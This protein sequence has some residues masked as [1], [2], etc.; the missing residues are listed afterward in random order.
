MT[1]YTDNLC[2]N[3]SVE[4]DLAG[5]VALAGTT[6][7][8]DTTQGKYGRNSMK[9]VTS[10]SAVGQGFTTPQATVPSTGTGSMSFHI[11]GGTGTLTISAI[12]GATPT[13]IASTNITMSGGDYQRVTLAGLPLTSGQA[14]YLLVQ[15]NS[16]EAL[17]FWVDAFQYEMNATPHPYIDGSF[18]NCT[19][20]GTP[21]SSSSFQAFQFP[22][23]SIGGLLLSGQATPVQ[24]GEIFQTSAL[25]QLRLSG[26]E[27]GTLTVNPAG[28]LSAFG[29]WTTADFDPAVSMAIYSNAQSSSGSGAWNRIYGT[30]Y[31]PQQALGSNGKAIWNRAAFA[32]PGFT[33]KSMLNNGQQITSD[34]QWERAPVVPGASPAPTTWQPPRQISATIKPSRLNFCPNP[35]MEVSAAGWT[36]IGSA[37]LSQDSSITMVQGTH[38][39][40]VAIHASTD[41]AYIMIPDLIVGD[42]Y[43]VS[44]YVQGGAGLE[45]VT[46]ACSGSSVSSANLGIPYGGDLTHGY[47]QGPYG[48]VE[49]TGADM[50]TGQWFRPFT[51]FVARASTVCLSFQIIAG[52]DISYPTAFWVDA[53][54]VETGDLLKDY[55][56]GGFG[57]DYSWEGGGTAGLTR[58]YYYQRQNVSAGAVSTALATHTPLGI[59][60]ASPVYSQPYTQ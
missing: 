7:S 16:A 14:M 4:N 36:A 8:L 38:G 26:T 47:G 53:V 57:T 45:D 48:G 32:A 50:P 28:A 23:G 15:T 17:T 44:A 13:V 2:V 34:V 21:G 43:A 12:S 9:V 35:S 29:I 18:A 37:T 58:S 22:T 39:L 52:T 56:D 20:N 10:G 24:E 41:G 19:W 25:G 5:Y 27:A 30:F 42:T 33:F 40:K 54:L 46:M 11:M 59:S 31:P 6:L 60:A 1:N 3:P 49:A 55:F 51:S